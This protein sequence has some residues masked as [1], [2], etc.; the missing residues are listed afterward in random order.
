MSAVGELKPYLESALASRNFKFDGTPAAIYS[1]KNEANNQEIIAGSLG[2]RSVPVMLVMKKE[3]TKDFKIAVTLKSTRIIN[4]CTLL[5]VKAQFNGGPLQG[6]A[7]W[8]GEENGSLMVTLNSETETAHLPLTVTG[9]CDSINREDG[10]CVD[11]VYVQILDKGQV[12]PSAK[13]RFY[14]KIKNP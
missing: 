9:A 7:H 8:V 11:F 5:T 12:N 4:L 1:L 6:A 10:S 14:V 2:S 3:D 13:K